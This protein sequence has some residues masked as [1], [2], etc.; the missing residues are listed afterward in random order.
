MPEAEIVAI[1]T[2]NIVPCGIGARRHPIGHA[3]VVQIGCS[4]WFAQGPLQGCQN[5]KRSGEGQGQAGIDLHTQHQRIEKQLQ[6]QA[7]MEL[8]GE[9]ELET[10]VESL[11]GE[12]RLGLFARR[13]IT[14]QGGLEAVL[15]C[16]MQ[17]VSGIGTKPCTLGKDPAH[18]PSQIGNR[19]RHN[20]PAE[21]TDDHFVFGNVAG[22]LDN[23]PGCR[24]TAEFL[25][26]DHQQHG[27]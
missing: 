12:E 2:E 26:Q 25:K 21:V 5:N 9:D 22:N 24:C 11:A 23:Q 1:A 17:H 16:E 27:G 4:Q 20:D 13:S 8:Q 7:Q 14:Q 19:L 18:R 6:N 10:D 15:T 3:L